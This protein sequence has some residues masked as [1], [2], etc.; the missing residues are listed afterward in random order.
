MK[1]TVW[2]IKRGVGYT[3]LMELVSFSKMTITWIDHLVPSQDGEG[4]C[5]INV[6]GYTHLSTKQT[7][8]EHSSW[9]VKKKYKPSFLVRMRLT[10]SYPKAC[11]VS[12]DAWQNGKLWQET[13][14]LK[15]SF[16]TIC[17]IAIVDWGNTRF[18]RGPII[19]TH[20]HSMSVGLQ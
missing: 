18:Q 14:L 1:Y 5:T 16:L 6:Q 20:T 12:I 3:N 4:Y 11:T 7:E 19:T 17:P 15:D 13:K 9:Q 8:C 2:C 10:Y